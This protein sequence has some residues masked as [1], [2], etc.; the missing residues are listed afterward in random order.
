MVSGCWLLSGMDII[1]ERGAVGSRIKDSS[2]FKDVLWIHEIGDS[3][4]LEIVRGS[5]RKWVDGIENYAQF[6]VRKLQYKG[7]L[8]ELA[9]DIYPVHE[10]FS[11][12]LTFKVRGIRK[13]T[14][15]PVLKVLARQARGMTGSDKKL[16]R[17]ARLLEEMGEDVSDL[18]ISTT[19]S[20]DEEAG[21][22]GE[23]GGSQR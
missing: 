15:K 22:E 4:I 13:D 6:V 3:R 17:I 19:P 7:V 18:G 9:S 23:E 16:R 14:L 20:S 12:T 21:G 10:G 1:D 5:I 2:I 8:I 11:I